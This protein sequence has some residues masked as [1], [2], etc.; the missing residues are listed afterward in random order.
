V[1]VIGADGDQ[2]GIM[3]PAEGIAIAEQEGLDLVEVAPDGR[4]PVCRIMDYG[5]YKYQQKKRSSEARRH[6]TQ[7]QVKE[8]KIR[9]KTEEHDYQVK[10][11]NAIRFLEAGNKAKITMMFRGREIAYADLAMKLMNR[12]AEDLA[13]L[14]Q[15]ESMPRVEGRNM[16]I[17]IAP[18]RDTKK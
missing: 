6:Q 8:V 15:V 16:T 11:R 2:L 10:K 18:R 3:P 12:L 5:K 13:E 4:P 7:I 14:G 1:R 17:M 9:P